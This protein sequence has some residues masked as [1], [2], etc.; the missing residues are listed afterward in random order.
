MNIGS[1]S[2]GD[3]GDENLARVPKCCLFSVARDS[4][5]A[6]SCTLEEIS[7]NA[8]PAAEVFDLEKKEEIRKQ[9]AQTEEFVEELRMAAVEVGSPSGDC[10]VEDA[11]SE[12]G[13]S[14]A[15]VLR[16]VRGYMD[17]ARA[18]LAEAKKR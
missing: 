13:V 6:V 18:Q 12:L 15:D 11:I 14:D 1:I 2:R 16:E 7:V 8:R 4:S 5:G 3:Y 10:G 9:T 17:Q